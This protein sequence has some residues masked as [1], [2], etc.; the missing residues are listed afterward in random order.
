MPAQSPEEIAASARRYVDELYNKH[1]KAIV[2]E[3]VAPDFV[4]RTAEPP[5]S[6]DREG[7]IQEA[8]FAHTAFPDLRFT[9]DDLIV[10]GDKMVMRWT[11]RGT[12]EG[13]FYGFPPTHKQVAFSG[14]TLA[15][16]SDGKVAESWSFGD[17]LGLMQ[18]LGVVPRFA[19]A[20]QPIAT[21][22]QAQ[23]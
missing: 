16:I 15:R 21:Q 2:Y 5:I 1:N 23:A 8:T 9:V 3:L 7:L 14:L 13:D 11:I 17:E 20:P 6:P 22:A 18:Q 10:T 12:H 19:F 4:Y